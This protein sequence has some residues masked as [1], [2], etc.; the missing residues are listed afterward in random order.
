[1]SQILS[2]VPKF[3]YGQLFITPPA[4]TKDC[5]GKTVIVT[6]SNTGLGL[7][8]ARQFV[9]LNA[10]KVILACRNLEKGEAAKKDIESTT[11]RNGVVEVWQLD[12]TSYESVKAF[13]KKSQS[14]ERLDILLENAGIAP[15]N[16]KLEEGSESTITV[17]VIST[18]LLALLMVPKLQETAKKHNTVPNLCIVSSEA[19]FLTP[20]LERKSSSIFDTLNDRSSARMTD[21]YNI[22][23]LLEVFV[24]REIAQDHP[25]SQLGMTLTFVNPGLCHSELIRPDAPAVLRMFMTV[26]KAVLARTTEVGARTLVD[27]SLRGQEDHGAFFSDCEVTEVAKLVTD[28]PETQTRVWRELAAKLEAIEPGVTKNLE[29]GVSAKL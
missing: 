21:R 6:G 3:I 19:H 24:C 29:R 20:F 11:G 26:M 14:L 15:P 2:F 8:A 12:L 18:F 13:A 16:F 5:A 25:V 7:E 23:K 9:Q 22:S 10:A 17:N 1:M 27:A 28:E 4:P